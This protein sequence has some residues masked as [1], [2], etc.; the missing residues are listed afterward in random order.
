M[1]LTQVGKA[2]GA[3]TRKPGDLPQPRCDSPGGFTEWGVTPWRA[4]QRKGCTV[5]M[6]IFG[7]PGP[8]GRPEG[9]AGAAVHG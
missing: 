9:F 6:A 1:P 8:Q 4:V 2:G 3:Q 7:T 5:A